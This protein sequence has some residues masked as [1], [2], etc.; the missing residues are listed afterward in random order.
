MRPDPRAETV[1]CYLIQAVRSSI[2]RPAMCVCVCV[3]ACSLWSGTHCVVPAALSQRM[4]RVQVWDVAAGAC[5]L[6]LKHHTDKVQALA[7][8]PAEPSGLL[9]GAF[10]GGACVCDARAGDSA[11]AA[12]SIGTDVESLAWNPHAPT[13][14][15]VSADDGHVYC[16][17]TR[18]GAGA[19]ALW[20]LGAHS[21]A[22]TA[23]VFCPAVDGLLVT[24]SVD[25]TVS[26]RAT[27][28]C[29][30]LRDFSYIT[31][32]PGH[33]GAR[34]CMGLG[35][36]LCLQTAQPRMYLLFRWR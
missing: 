12:W 30:Q 28:P 32:F 34:R 7:W 5:E 11:V 14:F 25:K 35:A 36:C 22:A 24:G 20:T 6:T 29:G 4:R 3:C 1:S 13:K 26:A 2:V 15:V 23:A 19:G 8:N 18:A 21:E 33:A 17:D 31:D 16:F 9:S 27:M 10:G